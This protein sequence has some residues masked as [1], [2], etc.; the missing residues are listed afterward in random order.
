MCLL[1]KG[2]IETDYRYNHRG[3][4]GGVC[5]VHVH[6]P[7]YHI[8]FWNVWNQEPTTIKCDIN[9]VWSSSSVILHQI[10]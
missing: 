4:S 5:R 7:T 1:N 8:M 10:S 3:G 9:V 6:M 2:I